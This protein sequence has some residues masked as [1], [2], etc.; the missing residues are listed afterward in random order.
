LPNNKHAI[1]LHR[2][3]EDIYLELRSN[4]IDEEEN[5]GKGNKNYIVLNVAG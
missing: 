2:K 3:I 1:R 4:D 5:I